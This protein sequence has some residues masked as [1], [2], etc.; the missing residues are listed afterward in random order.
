MYIF[1]IMCIT[2]TNI[3]SLIHVQLNKSQKQFIKIQEQTYNEH[4]KLQQISRYTPNPR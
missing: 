2:S 1:N 4:H 3:N